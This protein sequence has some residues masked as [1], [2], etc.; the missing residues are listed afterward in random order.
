[1]GFAI[2]LAADDFYGD[3]VKIREEVDGEGL[4]GN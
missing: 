3:R 2:E 4:E 1:M